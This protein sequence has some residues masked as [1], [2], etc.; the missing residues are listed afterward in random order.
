MVFHA[1]HR[2]PDNLDLQLNW[3]HL[4][5]ARAETKSGWKE[6][7]GLQGD[8]HTSIDG[9]PACTGFRWEE[10]HWCLFTGGSEKAWTES[11]EERIGTFP[12]IRERWNCVRDIILYSKDYQV[13]TELTAAAR[14]GFQHLL[15]ISRN[16]RMLI[17]YL[18]SAITEESG[19]GIALHLKPGR[20]KYYPQ[21]V[22][23]AS[24][25]PE[26]VKKLQWAGA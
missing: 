5:T 3:V 16:R 13:K 23:W 4:Q 17:Y 9:F 8:G 11:W 26:Y 1:P 25:S 20:W 15:L 22:M 12:L 18:I 24:Q 6:A 7:V 21:K 19:G 10:F 2:L 14:V